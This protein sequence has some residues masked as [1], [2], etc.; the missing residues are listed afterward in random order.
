MTDL[1][2]SA[3]IGTPTFDLARYSAPPRDIERCEV[4]SGGLYL[5]E[6]PR[7]EHVRQVEAPGQGGDVII[8]FQETMP[9]LDRQVAPPLPARTIHSRSLTLIP[10]GLATSWHCATGQPLCLH[11]HVPRSLREQWMEE[12]GN[13]PLTPLINCRATE[14]DDLFARITAE[15]RG[16]GAFRQLKLQGLVLAAVAACYRLGGPHGATTSGQA[17]TAARL[18]R[19]RAYVEENLDR[20]VCI[21]DLAGC[22]G[23]SPSHFS[24][25]FRAEVGMSPYAWV[26]QARIERVKERLLTTRKSLAEIAMDC[27]FGNQSHMTETFRRCVGL[28]PARWLREQGQD[29][30]GRAT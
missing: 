25:A 13:A 22:I 5:L 18:R 9:R 1:A 19:V 28:P 26:V 6:F 17:M 10:E 8:H 29:P 23:L 2:Y 11:I 3:R 16:A 15:L 24:R 14:L 12:L 30:A 4:F 20:E 21:E 27:G 7:M